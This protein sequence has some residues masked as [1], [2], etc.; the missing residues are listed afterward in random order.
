MKITEGRTAGMEVEKQVLF[1]GFGG[2]GVLSMGQ[3]LTYAAMGAGKQV[4]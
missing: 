1:A 4:A 3:F 2:Q